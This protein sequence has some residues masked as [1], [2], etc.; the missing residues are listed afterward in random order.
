M[1]VVVVGGL[2]LAFGQ[3]N[4]PHEI[5]QRNFRLNPIGLKPIGAD[6]Y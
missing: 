3:L 2:S 6:C 4:E 5:C 1:V